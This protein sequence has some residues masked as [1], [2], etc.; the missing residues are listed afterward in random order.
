MIKQDIEIPLNEDKSKRYR[1]FEVLPGALSWGL[2]AL[3]F[4]LSLISAQITALFILAFILMWFARAVGLNVRVLQ[5]WKRLKTYEK[6]HW[7]SYLDD[8]QNLEATIHDAPDWH[9][10]NIA[11]LQ[12]NPAP[13]KPRDLYHALFVAVYNES[14]EIVEPTIESILK[15]DYDMKK[16]I[17][18]IAYEGRGGPDV[19]KMCNEITQKYGKQF[20]EAVAI[21]HPDGLPNEVRGKGGNIT[22]AARKFQEYLEKEKIDPINVV[23]TTLDSD[24]RPHK[25]YL[26]LLSYM[27]ASVDDPEHYSFQPV[28]IYTNNIWDAPAPM[29]V[30]ATGNSF[31]NIVLSMRPHM[32]RNFSSHAQGM[33]P[34]IETDF[35]STRTIV[36]DGHQFWRTYFRYDGE[37]YVLPMYIPIYQ[38][39]V[40]DVSYLKTLKMQFIQLRRWAWGA[41]DVA[42]VA[43]KAFFS[44]NK[45]LSK[46]DAVFKFMRLVEGH[47]SWAAAPLILALA[48]FIPLLFNPEDFTANQLPQIASRIQTVAMLGIIITLFLSFKAL[49]PKPKRY[50]AHRNIFMVLQWVL[51]PVTSIGYS[52]FSALYSQTRLMFGWYLGAFDV[53]TKHVKTDKVKKP[54]N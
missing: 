38:D 32:I 54:K 9:K 21:K 20:Y 42:Y 18:V 1:F 31:W 53:T 44:G 51:L 5:G 52:S 41:S 23:V 48:A 30:I 13:V 47:L 8:L 35:W 17:L 36:E 46:V 19:E 26:G 45:K 49:P 22:Y 12:A 50:K 7:Q 33:K 6:M 14:M 39:A 29:R 28:P 40:L 10:S 27:Y 4:I 37:H 16:V 15:M 25:N 3:P 2:L 11:R 24:N 43:E 34:L